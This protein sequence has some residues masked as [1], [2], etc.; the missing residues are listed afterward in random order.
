MN[1]LNTRQEQD[2][3]AS[4]RRGIVTR[5]V[6]KYILQR[7]GFLFFICFISTTFWR[8]PW[9]NE[10]LLIIRIFDNNENDQNIGASSS[11]RK[12]KQDKL[13]MIP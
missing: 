10:L 8:K 1:V 2:Y 12:L 9:R 4:P 13:T 7:K 3:K 11:N 5:A 6:D